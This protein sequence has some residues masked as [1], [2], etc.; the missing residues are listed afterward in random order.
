MLFVVPFERQHQHKNGICKL[1]WRNFEWA[2]RMKLLIWKLKVPCCWAA[3]FGEHEL[4]QW[5]MWHWACVTLISSSAMG[6]VSW[7]CWKRQ[8]QH[9]DK[10]NH[11]TPRFARSQ[12][13]AFIEFLVLFLAFCPS[14]V[15]S[16]PPALY[17]IVNFVAVWTALAASQDAISAPNVILTTLFVLPRHINSDADCS[18]DNLSSTGELNPDSQ[19]NAASSKVFS[20]K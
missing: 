1:L 17:P 9:S 3:A 13:A 2:T 10:V 5:G 7:F 14:A 15:A 11:P 8:T 4:V 19:P 18:S 12:A 20:Q 6:P 16:L